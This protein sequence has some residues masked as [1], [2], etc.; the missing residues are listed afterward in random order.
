MQKLQGVIAHR[1]YNLQTFDR[2]LRTL[3]RIPYSDSHSS[4]AAGGGGGPLSPL[5]PRRILPPLLLPLQL[6]LHSQ[7][8]VFTRN[9][10]RAYTPTPTPIILLLFY[11]LCLTVG[12][13]IKI[14]N[15]LKN[16][17]ISRALSG[18]Q[19]C[20]ANDVALNDV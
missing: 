14:S 12:L 17:K 5:P 18:F 19:E 10:R 6:P 20:D 2:S 11:I 3:I 13:L 15:H 9:F 1:R 7:L 16:S 4:F 8:K